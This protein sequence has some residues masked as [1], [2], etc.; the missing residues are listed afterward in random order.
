MDR[1]SELLLYRRICRTVA[2]TCVKIE[3][4]IVDVIHIYALSTDRFC[5]KVRLIDHYCALA[6][7][8]QLLLPWSEL[9]TSSALSWR[10]VLSFV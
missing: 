2:D 7:T 10:S 5:H 6:L 1:I 8:G 9:I 3:T 4:E